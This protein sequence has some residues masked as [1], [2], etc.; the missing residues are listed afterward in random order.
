MVE[1]FFMYSN[2]I[3]ILGG[4]F[5]PVH[6]GHVE[7]ADCARKQYP[8]IESLV[9]MPNAMTYYKDGTAIA[10]GEDRVAMLRLATSHIEHVEI[11]EIELARGGI[12]YTID[13]LEEIHAVNPGLKIYFIIGADSLAWFD[14]W[15]RFSDILSHATILCARRDSDLNAM[16]K[17]AEEI[18]SKAGHG[19]ILFLDTPEFPVSSTEIRTRILEGKDTAGMLTTSVRDYIDEHGLYR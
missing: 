3:A 19:E 4:T 11:S 14:N 18:I 5:N 10:S 17:R 6:C 13:T 16:Q 15:V 12:T 2:C 1:D 7:I 8:D 9:F